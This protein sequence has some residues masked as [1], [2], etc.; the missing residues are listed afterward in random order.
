MVGEQTNGGITPPHATTPDPDDHHPVHAAVL[1]P[2]MDRR[3]TGP[4]AGRSDPNAYPLA[5]RDHNPHEERQ[6]DAHPLA[7]L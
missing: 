5:L 3:A 1:L 6:R 7:D 2:G 4:R